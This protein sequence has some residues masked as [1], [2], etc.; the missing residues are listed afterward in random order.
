MTFT[1]AQW[2]RVTGER[3]CPICDH[4]GY[5]SID[6]VDG[7]VLCMRTE[8]DEAVASGGWLHRGDKPLDL[9]PPPRREKV[10]TDWGKVAAAC[11]ARITPEAVDK[12]AADLGVDPIALQELGIGTNGIDW[13]FPMFNADGVVVGVRR[14]TPRG[15]KFAMKGAYLGL[16]R[17]PQPDRDEVLIV[18]EGESD[19]AAMLTLGLDA[20]GLPGVGTCHDYAAAYA[21]G[22][23]VI[24]ML[25]A[26]DAGAKATAR[27]V[28]MLVRTAKTVR[29]VRPP[30]GIKDARAWLNAGATRA[31]VEAAIAAAPIQQESTPEAAATAPEEESD[32]AIQF[33]PWLEL[34]K[35][36]PVHWSVRRLLPKASIA[37][38]AGDTQAGK[39]FLAIDLALR[40]LCGR[41]YLGHPTKPGSVVYLC[42]EGQDGFAARLRAWQQQN[43]AH[44]DEAA[45]RYLEVSDVIPRLGKAHMGKLRNL[46]AAFAK[47]HGHAPALVVVDTLSQGLEGDENDAEVTAPVLRGLA[48]I[49]QRFGCSFLIVHHVVK[50]PKLGRDEWHSITLNDVRGSGAITRNADTVLGVHRARDGQAWELVVLKQKDGAKVAPIRFDRLVVETG[51]VDNFGDRETS[52]VIVPAAAAAE[53]GETEV[54]RRSRRAEEQQAAIVEA[55]RSIGG[56]TTSVRAVTRLVPGQPADLQASFASAICAG[57]IERKKV[58]GQRMYA[59]A[60]QGALGA[61]APIENMDKCPLA[62]AES[63]EQGARGGRATKKPPSAPKRPLGID[64]GIPEQPKRRRTR[65]TRKAGG[66]A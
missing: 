59:L 33:A 17:R 13:T 53:S 66:A 36:P 1:E 12:L 5:C 20:V 65:R 19:T 21:I 4:D 64:G 47:Q 18:C 61:G 57:L 9:P 35:R 55:L 24:V 60:R 30:D 31:D 27:L 54:Q 29:V 49:R 58:Q 40:M 7:T 46:I 43:S 34:L 38:L 62:P 26:D 63:G 37:I 23:D 52:C 15:G 2:V 22:R 44:P 45:G 51:L 11:R 25:D 42:G 32:D 41:N 50:G 3:R 48:K 6:A 39:S 56:T 16:I 14:R 10:S 8:S 28:P